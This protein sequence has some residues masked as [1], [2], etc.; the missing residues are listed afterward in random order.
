MAQRMLRR[1]M[2]RPA[3]TIAGAALTAVM[4]GVVVN[5]LV[6]QK[7]RR[8]APPAAPIATPGAAAL[9]PPAAPAPPVAP[10]P[11]PAQPAAT[12]AD[13][14]LIVVQPP[15]RPADLGALIEATA[16]RGGDP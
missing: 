7:G 4:V 13:H 9:A 8:V 14:T 5:A 3:R 12:S 1:L 10:A 2:T 11:S 16:P 15:S 6:L